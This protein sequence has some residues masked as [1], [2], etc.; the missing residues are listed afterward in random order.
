MAFFDNLNFVILKRKLKER[1]NALFHKLGSH[2]ATFHPREFL[3]YKLY[4]LRDLHNPYLIFAALG[5][6]RDDVV[7]PALVETDIKLIDLDLTDTAHGCSEVVLQA[8][9]C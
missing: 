9:G 4:V 1:D 6:D 7:T 5:L 3:P 8:V 2:R